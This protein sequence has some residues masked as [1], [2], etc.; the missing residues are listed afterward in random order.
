M[1]PDVID[2]GSAW[3]GGR[4]WM[5]FTPYNGTGDTEIPSVVVASDISAGGSWAV[6]AGF[7]NPITP[8]PAGTGH[9]ADTDSVYDATTSRLHVLY[10]STDES[11]YQDIRSK[12]TTGDGTWS[13]ETTVL[14]GA[15]NAYTNP[16]VIKTATGWR[17]Y[18]TK[19]T[20]ALDGL[21]Y[22]DTTTT[23][24]SG[25]GAEQTA[26]L[27]LNFGIYSRKMQNIQAVKD[28]D[29]SVVIIVS[30]GRTD[31]LDGTLYFARSTDG[32]VTFTITGPPVLEHGGPTAWDGGGIYRASLLVDTTSTVVV[33]GGMVDLWYSGYLTVAG[34]WGIAWLRIPVEFIRF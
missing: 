30:D 8:D 4:Y 20:G 1:H 25:Y 14:A 26:T 27:S 3:H 16:S 12:Y 6:P 29:G 15:A 22:R 24:V 18:Y 9:M 28:T 19:D 5:A 21:Y 10:V 34:T 2:F 13:T 23:P 7:T 32:G 11:T 33:S 31:G 17:M